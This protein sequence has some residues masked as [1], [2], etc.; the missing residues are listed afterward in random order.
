MTGFDGF[1]IP[2]LEAGH[3]KEWRY[4]DA[5]ALRVRYPVLSEE[6]VTKIWERLAVNRD[7]RLI[8]TPVSRIVAAI[9]AAAARLHSSREE[10][11]PLLSQ[12][13]GYSAAVIAET[14]DHMLADWSAAS[15]NLMLA[16]ELGDARVLDHPIADRDA[17]NKHT[18]AFGFRKTFHIFSGNV[19]GVAVT[20]LIRSLL[21]KSATFGKTASGDPV[22]PVLFARALHDVAPDIAGS[23]AI[24]YWPHDAHATQRSALDLADAVVVYGG[25]DAVAAV[26]QAARAAKR[27]VI[28]GPRLSFG[29]V[30]PDSTDDVARDVARAVAAYDQQGCVS[31]HVVYVIGAAERAR[32]FARAVATHLGDLATALP[33]GV[34]TAEEAVAIRNARTA[35]EFAD[36]AELF[37]AESGGFSVIYEASPEFKPSCLNRVLYVKPL[38]DAH[39]VMVLLPEAALLQSAALAGFPETTKAEL[40][41]AL[42]LRGV[43]RITSFA[44]LPWPPMHWHHDGGAPLRELLWWQDIES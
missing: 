1:F 40:A 4:L 17:T 25:A 32:S 14:L 6:E 8:E 11:V 31:P 2:G 18:A 39:E 28:H 42:G 15:L 34:L 24:A 36:A 30:G 22:L 7:S 43:S 16:A 21:V 44:R 23:I 37:G 10:V 13:T 41:R 9:D 26:T 20:S 29:I 35:A 3:I 19:P 27:I 38:A 5:G 33:R 12:T